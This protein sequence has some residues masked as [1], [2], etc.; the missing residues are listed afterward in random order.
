MP[1]PF[2][3]SNA[4][5]VGESYRAPILLLLYAA[6][7]CIPARRSDA[8]QGERLPSISEALVDRNGDFVPDRLG[9]AV[10]VV[11][12]VT[13]LPQKAG[14][15]LRYVAIQDRSAGVRLLA[16]DSS[17]ML[18]QLGL[19][20]TVA[21]EGVL[22]EYHGIPELALTRLSRLGSGLPLVPQHALAAELRSERFA[23]RLVRVFGRLTIS[24]IDNARTMVMFEDRSGRIP[25]YLPKGLLYDPLIANG[26]LHGGTLEMDAI[27]GKFTDAR[28]ANSG[29]RLAPRDANDLRFVPEPP[30]ALI[31]VVTML[32]FLSLLS[33]YLWMRRRSAEERSRQMELLARS[34]EESRQA[35][36][37]QL[38]AEAARASSEAKLCALFGAMRAVVLVLSREGRYMLI[39]ATNADRLYAPPEALLGR[40]VHEVLPQAEA[41]VICATIRRALDQV[42]PVHSRYTRVIGGKTVYF[43]AVVSPLDADTVVWVAHDVT[44]HRE[45]EL[46]VR[47]AHETLEATIDVAPQA[48][49]AV[50]AEWRV[51][52]WNRA[53]EEMFGWNAAEVIGQPLPYIPD[54]ERAAFAAIQSLEAHEAGI[55]ALG[56][57][58]VRKDGTVLDVLLSTSVLRDPT[59]RHTGFIAL[60]ADVSDRKA[61][62]AQLRQAQKLEAVGQLAGG[63]AHDFNNL[64][65]VI[66]A[67]TD[68]LLET[69]AAGSSEASD[70]EE[71]RH[72]ARRAAGLT[73]Q[74]L[75]FSRR[76]IL[77]PK[78]IELNAVVG[79]FGPLL[80]RLIGEDIE[81]SLW[82][83]AEAACVLA[84]P[85]Q[86]EQVLMNLAVNAR[87]AMPRGGTLSIETK[88]VQVEEGDEAAIRLMLPGHY[89]LL[90]VSDTGLGMDAKTQARIFEPFF[91]TKELGKGTGLGLSTV[92]GIVKQSGGFIW[93]ESASGRGTTFEIYL[94]QVI[95]C[96]EGEQCNA[97][98]ALPRGT[99]T[100]LLV[101]DDDS[102]RSL[103][104]RV[105]LRQG[106]SVL[107]ARNGNDAL[108]LLEETTGR[109]HLVLTDVVMPLMNGRALA[110]RIAADFPEMPVLFMSG[111]TD[112][113]IIRRGALPSGCAFLQKPFT[114]DLLAQTVRETLDGGIAGAGS[115]A[116]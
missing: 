80:R 70:L 93:C 81:V 16:T 34:S 50:D 14:E 91:T 100:V 60:V 18:D 30:Y 94:P 28:P 89:A 4:D 19:G 35:V 15:H 72:A 67:H 115:K 43:D 98:T 1:K 62:E 33:A 109:V 116:A 64:L 78:V 114:A 13:A 47:A 51:T 68:F 42:Q 52:R 10:R 90:K 101:E 58:R 82:P 22:Q 24:K 65:T 9:E 46:A 97:P 37:R 56:T 103:A 71:I 111:Y 96:A 25:V 7:L 92:Y 95:A 61:L 40:T 110:N 84:D 20:D 75:A 5:L 108:T 36:A 3:K 76:Q 54:S 59:G 49:V 107:E 113:D 112:D 106:Y 2:N 74:L 104:R 39:P 23:G 86:L 45:A 102:V 12:V 99:E 73:A 27:A 41:E 31:A 8:Q 17:H 69:I 88:I 85:G 105:L 6:L 83:G 11:G 87:D 44:P 21:A 53:A 79:Q 26:V 57:R 66:G 55:R 77:Q 38:E 29:Y 32:I 63:I 48:I